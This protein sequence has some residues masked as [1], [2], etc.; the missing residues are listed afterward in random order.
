MTAE[1]MENNLGTIAHSGSLAFKNENEKQ[2]DIDI[3]GQFGVGFY[4][5]FVAE[6]MLRSYPVRQAATGPTAG[7]PTVRTATRLA[8][9]EKAENGTKIVL[10]IKDNTENENYDRFLEPYRIQGL[11]KKYSDYIRYPIK[12]DMT[13]SRMKEK[14][15]DAVDDYKPEWEGLHRE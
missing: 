2:D 11:V 15:A 7:S 12:M 10:T 1:E 3:I 9:C 8:P 5:V 14:P 6:S 4:A 13:R